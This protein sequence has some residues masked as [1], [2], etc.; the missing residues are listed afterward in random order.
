[1]NRRIQIDI[2]GTNGSYT[3][4]ITEKDNLIFYD[5]TA[6]AAI[7]GKELA[8]HID[9]ME[10]LESGRSY[11]SS[12][13]DS[14]KESPYY[15]GIDI[16]EIFVPGKYV[17]VQA[18]YSDDN[19][20]FTEIEFCAKDVTELADLWEEYCDENGVSP[21]SVTGF[22][23]VYSEEDADEYGDDYYSDDADM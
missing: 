4:F 9:N 10:M 15:M 19:D 12:E 5:E 6:N 11:L 16:S 20:S 3:V 7:I 18:H 1:M 21:N 17:T 8:R 23:R 13:C 22:A 2:S 14:V